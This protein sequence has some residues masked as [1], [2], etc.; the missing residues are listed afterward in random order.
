MLTLMDP[1]IPDVNGSM[2]YY[3]KKRI[4]K[5]L[6]NCEAALIGKFLSIEKLCENQSVKAERAKPLPH[7]HEWK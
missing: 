3:S 4:L 2:Q 7:P 5:L 6:R 1:I